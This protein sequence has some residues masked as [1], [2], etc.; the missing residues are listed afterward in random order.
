[1]PDIDLQ[2]TYK[3]LNKKYFEGKL[4]QVEIVY[5]NIHELPVKGSIGTTT[6]E[7]GVPVKI[8]LFDALAYMGI[9]LIQTLL[10]EMAHVK[11]GMKAGHGKKFK[12]ELLRLHTEGAY[13]GLL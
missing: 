5:C 11:L 2:A 1:M 7:N 3:L 10:H 12:A 13:N 9:F 6:F 4:P 8:W